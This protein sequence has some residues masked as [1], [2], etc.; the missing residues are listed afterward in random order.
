MKVAGG[1]HRGTAIPRWDWSGVDK[2]RVPEI[3]GESLKNIYQMLPV[4]RSSPQQLASEISAL[5]A[6]YH[7]YLYQDE[8]GSTRAECMAALRET[9]SRVRLLDSLIG[10]LPQHLALELS[11]GAAEADQSLSFRVLRSWSILRGLTLEQIHEAASTELGLRSS[12]HTA[13]DLGT[14]QEICAR[15]ASAMDAVSRL[16]TNSGGELFDDALRTGLLFVNDEFSV[17][18]APLFALK[19]QVGLTL[20]RLTKRKGPE[21]QVSLSLLVWEACELWT[22]ET[23]KPVTNSAFR[24]ARYTGAPESLAGKFV[25]AVVEALQPSKSWV[26]DRL[27]PDAAIRARKFAASP[28]ARARMVHFAMRDYVAHHRRPGTRRG[29]PR[30]AQ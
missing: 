18:D 15:A 21:R 9:H 20:D 17:I 5:G 25:V 19:A 22:R 24:N 23:G 7:R 12:L 26:A 8:F 30:V 27:P 1:T 4:K 10:D 3:C 6:R 2:L 11:Y 29:R 28:A 13:D 16:D 14:L